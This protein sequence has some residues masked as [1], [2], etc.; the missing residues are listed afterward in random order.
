MEYNSLDGLTNEQKEV[1][2]EERNCLLIACPGSGK[3]KTI[4]HRRAYLAEKYKDSLKINA[5]ITYTNKAADEIRER[6]LDM[7]IPMESVW[8]GTIH[9]FC[10]TF[11]IEPYSLHD[12]NV[13]YG[14]RVVNKD[15]KDKD[16]KKVGDISFDNI[17]E[18]AK[19][20]LQNHKFIASNVSHL[21]RTI[22][23][24]EYQDTRRI[25]YEILAELAKSNSEIQFLFAGDPNQSIY[26]GIGSVTLEMD[27]LQILF[28]EPFIGKQLTGCYRSTQRVIDY[29]RR[30]AIRPST[31]KSRA[32]N[33]LFH[34]HIMYDDNI[35]RNELPMRIAGIIKQEIQDGIPPEEI[36]VAAPQWHMIYKMSSAFQELLP[37]VN[38]DAPEIAPF[39]YDQSNPF[40]WLAWLL[41][42]PRRGRSTVREKIAVKCIQQLVDMYDLSLYKNYNESE[43]LYKLNHITRLSRAD[44]A[45]ELYNDVCLKVLKTMT[46][47]DRMPVN[48]IEDYE[49]YVEAAQ[50]RACKY[51]IGITIENYQQYYRPRKGIVMSTIYGLKG[52]EFTTVIGYGL[53]YG[54]IPHRNSVFNYPEDYC[55]KE[56]KRLLYVLAS[57]AKENIYL[58]SEKGER[59]KKG[60]LYT[61]TP[62]LASADYTYD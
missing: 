51:N 58:F 44:T 61:A 30:F 10:L 50:K 36:C 41:F 5:A 8:I 13:A 59:T 12:E 22:Q 62:A 29:Y 49:N 6:L 56:S 33:A 32:G 25:Q 20:L 47:Q 38:I 28:G 24:D 39:E 23:V 55:E 21:F 3:T 26:T 48:L 54:K 7:N 52:L 43:F 45:I 42:S 1:C 18:I 40:Y 17:L 60:K 9:R 37:D 11:I 4:V 15:D 2:C 19:S 53:L 57:R 31:I 16:K 14:F 46:M 27:G 35:S 34:G